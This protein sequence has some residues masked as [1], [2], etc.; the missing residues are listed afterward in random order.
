VS[1]G[2]FSD[3]PGQSTMSPSDDSGRCLCAHRCI[4]ALQYNAQT[5][6]PLSFLPPA[7]PHQTVVSRTC[8]SCSAAFSIMA[9]FCAICSTVCRLQQDPSNATCCRQTD[10]GA[11]VTP[12]SSGL[13]GSRDHHIAHT[14][15]LGMHPTDP[16]L[17][18][19][20]PSW[21]QRIAMAASICWAGCT[22][23]AAA[24]APSAKTDVGTPYHTDLPC[25][26]P[27]CL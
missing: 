6:Y 3:M 22:F 20:G 2:S 26:H 19:L 1:L 25:L 7:P 13:L 8:W 10:C 5:C 15:E 17:H 4:A 12:P 9:G 24:P 23:G 16:I 27:C 21:H 18:H 14:Q 11:G